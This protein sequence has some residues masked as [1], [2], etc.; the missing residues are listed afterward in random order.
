MVSSK[1]C[2]LT[3]PAVS[4]SLVSGEDAP[5]Y[6]TEHT[7]PRFYENVVQKYNLYVSTNLVTTTFKAAFEERG[8]PRNLTFSLHPP[9]YYIAQAPA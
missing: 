2:L 9:G 8:Q 5:H 1:L 6:R 4:C 3:F 7:P